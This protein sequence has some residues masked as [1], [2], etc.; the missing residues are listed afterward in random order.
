M[1]RSLVAVTAAL[2]IVA[3]SPGPEAH[4]DCH[5]ADSDPGRHRCH[6]RFCRCAKACKR[7]REQANFTSCM[8]TCFAQHV[9]C[10]EKEK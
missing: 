2:V 4:T 5:R 10:V 3:M 6:H 8:S 1:M 7:K 9:R